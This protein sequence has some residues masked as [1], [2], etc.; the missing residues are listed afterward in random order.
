MGALYGKVCEEVSTDEEADEETDE[1]SGSGEDL[2][3]PNLLLKFPYI[4][5]YLIFFI[6]VT[7][8]EVFADT[9]EETPLDYPLWLKGLH[10]CGPL[11]AVFLLTASIVALVKK[12]FTKGQCP[13]KICSC[14]WESLDSATLVH[15][16]CITIMLTFG[17]VA[18]LLHG[19]MISRRWGGEIIGTNRK[20]IGCTLG[21]LTFLALW[22]NWMC[23]A[24][25]FTSPGAKVVIGLSC[26]AAF[27]VVFV[28]V[29]RFGILAS[30]GFDA[31]DFASTYFNYDEG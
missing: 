26:C 12:P 30:V 16:Y 24:V 14:F 9:S 18:F 19:A 21:Q 5:F 6:L 10:L 7:I 4:C 22:V 25:D 20:L 29:A 15:Q 23:R 27:T 28:M 11:F 13:P 17:I 3:E 2:D 1:D 8:F 31:S